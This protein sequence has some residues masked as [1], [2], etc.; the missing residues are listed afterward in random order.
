MI[1]ILR[2]QGNSGNFLID[3]RILLAPRLGHRHLFPNR[4][5]FISE[6][7]IRRYA[8]FIPT[9]FVCRVAYLQEMQENSQDFRYEVLQGPLVDR[10]RTANQT[11]QDDGIVKVWPPGCAMFAEYRHHA[12][13]VRR[14][15]VREDDVWVVTY[16][17]AGECQ[18]LTNSLIG[19]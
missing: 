6:G 11:F 12:E 10:F 2:L 14:F 5:Q 17:K 15:E 7:T 16:P 9:A 1:K 13:R 3:H 4:L 18:W 19:S 8:G